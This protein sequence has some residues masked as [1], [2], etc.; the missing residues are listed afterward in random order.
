MR[1]G[2]RDQVAHDHAAGRNFV[3][4]ERRRGLYYQ[5]SSKEYVEFLAREAFN[6]GTPA[7]N[8]MC[9]AG[10]G[11]PYSVGPQNRSRGEYLFELW[12][13]PQ[14]YGRSP[15]VAIDHATLSL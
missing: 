6:S 3:V 2:N 1:I 9:L 12:G 11:R 5:T 10:P 8:L 14:G 15:P 4:A 7:E 13:S